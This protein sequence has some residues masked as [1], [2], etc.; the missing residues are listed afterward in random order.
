M[1]RLGW[2]VAAIVPYMAITVFVAG[3]LYR[4]SIWVRSPK[5][6]PMTLYPTHGSGTLALVREAMFFP[7]LYKGDKPFWLIAW[8]FH[9]A[10][11][12]AFVGHFR[13]V[14]GIFDRALGL[15]P[16]QLAALSL[17][18]GGLAGALLILG[19]LL[20]LARR[21]VLTRVREI[22]KTPDFLALLLLVAVIASGNLLRF[23][24]TPVDLEEV[25]SWFASLVAFSPAVPNH[26]YFILHVLCAETLLF[27]IAFSKL[28][29][30]G[31]LFF[32]IRLIKTPAQ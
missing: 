9:A 1:T 23:G 11:A 18:L 15:R 27:Y 13:A 20:L 12:L 2:F 22:S 26:G 7:S 16:E 28:M 31:G 5:Q 30:F 24:P 17:A 4:F 10:L 29:H 14:S 8:S 25:R 3:V 6:P 21:L 32:S 19:A